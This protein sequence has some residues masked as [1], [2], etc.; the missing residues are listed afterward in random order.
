M[1]TVALI[2]IILVII[3]IFTLS[4]YIQNIKHTQ[5][6]N[7]VLA[8]RKG[9]KGGRIYKDGEYEHISGYYNNHKRDYT[10]DDITWNDLNLTEVFNDLNY[11]ESS[12]GEEYLYY[13][14]RNPALDPK[15]LEE[16]ED[17][18]SY[19]SEQDEDRLAL[20]IAFHRCGRTGK[21]SIYDY[22]NNLGQLDG[23]SAMTDI[24]LVI[25]LIVSVLITVFVSFKWISLTAIMLIA[26]G[27]TYF[28]KKSLIEPYI[29]CF[30]YVFR[31][32]NGAK[33]VSD[34][35]CGEVLDKEKQELK[36]LLSEFRGFRRFSSLVS[37]NAGGGNP[38]DI[39]YDYLKIFTHID[40]IKFVHMKH[41]LAKH[42]S[43]IDRMLTVM[44]RI[45][46]AVS[47]ALYRAYLGS[48][49]VPEFTSGTYSVRNIYHP[50]L[51]EPVANDLTLK[52]GMILTGSNAS[53]KSTM[54][55]TIALN[56]ILAQSFHTVAAEEYKADMY[57]VYTS[58]ALKDDIFAGESY[59]MT[60]I[61]TLKK[62][63][64]KGHEEGNPILV[65]VDE[66]LRG[67]NT[68][69]RIAAGVAILK[70]FKDVN[71]IVNAASHDLE[72]ARMLSDIYDNH[73][74]DE[75]ID[76]DDIS[77]SYKLKDGIA[78]TRNAIRLLEMVGYDNMITEEA[79]ELAAVLSREM[80]RV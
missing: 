6:V 21:Y 8:S 60:E 46:A 66:V 40:I 18:I 54:L 11:T 29:I 24:I 23:L 9:K 43:D 12:A 68:I 75:I 7:R 78:T 2:I 32:L 55:K 39:L 50:L 13:L 26:L 30:S 27:I 48:Y 69:E 63:I 44:G 67:T 36:E 80:I 38:L 35:K 31:I 17:K 20:Q 41:E 62:I 37:N 57:R 19:F 3:A 1:D 64:D 71:G 59:Y 49:C 74:F 73:H 4:G 28:K 45:E 33:V 58:L 10:V 56:A 47:I 76:N 22:M 42:W 52:G 15:E 70:A 53:G 51:E 34:V 25:C 16:L 5:Y 65:C 14:L 72:L 77:F 79:K 61:K